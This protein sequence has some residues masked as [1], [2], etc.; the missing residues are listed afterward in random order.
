MPGQNYNTPAARIAKFKGEI[1]A[2]AIPVEVLGITGT[3]RRMPKNRSSTVVYRR[4]LPYGATTGTAASINRWSVD[5]Q[6]HETQE[7][8]T[9]DVDSLTPDD[10]TVQLKQYSCL[11]MYTDKV[12]DLYEDNVPEEMKIQTGERMGLVREMIRYGAL[13][14]STN[15][16][17]AGGTSRGTV[18]EAVSKTLLRRMTRSIKG[19]RGKMITKVLDASPNYNTA[20]VEAGYLVFCHTDLESDIRD[21]PGFTKCAEYGSRKSIHEHEIGS[22]DSYRFIVSPELASIADSGAAVGTTGLYSTSGSNV[23]VY[24]MIVVAADAWADVALRGMNSFDPTSIPHTTKT[25]DDP[26]GQRGYC[27]AKFWS[28]AF[29]QN[30]GWMAV[31]EVGASALT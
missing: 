29:V 14:G 5:A 3:Q 2:H 8:V 22:V 15:K 12:A 10:R 27:G 26:L 11:Y 1:L 16:F 30:D 24:P 6:A 31:A 4:W 18:D 19:N 21:L 13:K 9:P 25:K 23:D 20:P 7:G 17:Y 28:A